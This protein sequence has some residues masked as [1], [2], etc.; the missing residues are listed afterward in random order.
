MWPGW[1]SEA[2]GR[3]VRLRCED[4]WGV[5]V[6]GR[7]LLW[8]PWPEG[9]GEVEGGVTES[10]DKRGGHHGVSGTPGLGALAVN[11]VVPVFP[12]RDQLG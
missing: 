9:F 12:V 4:T 8:G 7:W 11:G 6:S 10:P 3:G 5:S 1:R 2:W